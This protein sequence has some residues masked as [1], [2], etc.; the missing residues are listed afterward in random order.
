M[1]T[2]IVEFYR[3]QLGL[4]EDIELPLELTAGELVRA[5]NAAYNLGISDT[6]PRDQY[7]CAEN[8]IAF[9]RGERTLEAY[10]IREGSV[11]IFSRRF[12]QD[13]VRFSP[14]LPRAEAGGSNGTAKSGGCL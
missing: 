5:L 4:R 7:L 6:D 11:I 2:V 12:G 13:P 3:P 8:P 1:H 10:G 14:A 9:L